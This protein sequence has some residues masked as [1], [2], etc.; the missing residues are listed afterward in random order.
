MDRNRNAYTIT[1]GEIKCGSFSCEIPFALVFDDNG[2]FYIET[3]L[4]NKQFYEQTKNIG[5]YSLIGKTEKGYDIEISK[6][7]FHRL[8]YAN[9]KLE[10]ICYGSLKL[11]DN[12]KEQRELDN[13]N[14]YDYSIYVIEVE[15]LKMEFAHHTTIERFRNDGKVDD[16]LNF[17]FDHTSCAMTI[18]FS[19][20][21][22]NYYK[23]IFTKNPKTDNILIDF[24]KHVGYNRLTYKNYLLIKDSFLSFL[25][26][27]N[28]GHV[29]VRKEMT[30]WFITTSGSEY[31]NSQCVIIYSR[32]R[33]TTKYLSNFIPANEHHSYSSSIVPH[34]FINCFDH[35]YR[36]NKQL[37]FISLVFSLNNSTETV[38]LEEKY[39][40]L[41]TALEKLCSNYAK[42]IR[43]PK[44]TLIDKDTFIND[45]KPEL[46]AVLEKFET[47]I[48]QD[49]LSAWAIFKSKIGNINK[50]N[51]AETSQKLYELFT[52]SRIPINNE[53][54]SLIETE[55][56]QAVHEGVIGLTEH[57]RIKNYWKLDHILRDIILNLIDYRSYRNYTY[58]YYE[59]S[60]I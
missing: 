34:M 13:S 57:D 41:I 3:F 47:V 29:T 14:Q 2:V 24:S 8:K 10:L 5:F 31:T 32:K 60:S 48:K 15:G 21:E 55:R 33:E 44:K 59:Q 39:F 16:L 52:Y 30:G 28:G 26:F 25:S 4:P 58:K 11:S 53:V 1:K 27:L 36:L 7:S 9:L 23:L 43:Q 51:K 19:E 17:D 50:S 40:I 12:R 49:N 45:I 56:N 18:N 46:E 6:L 42:T 22:G 35:Y 20:K 38:G 37:D 54:V